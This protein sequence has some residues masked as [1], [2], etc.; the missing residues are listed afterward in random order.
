VFFFFRFSVVRQLITI[1]Q[2]WFYSLNLNNPLNIRFVLHDGKNI[3]TDKKVSKTC[4]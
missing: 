2:S 3:T 1:Q 4:K